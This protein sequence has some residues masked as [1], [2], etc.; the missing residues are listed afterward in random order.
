MG[1]GK[2]T[3]RQKMIGMMYLVLLALLAMNVSKSV[4]EAFVTLDTKMYNSLVL[5]DE[6]NDGIV[7]S[8]DYKIA[9]LE[10][11]GGSD[12]E[13]ENIRVWQ[14]RALRIRKLTNDISNYYVQEAADM[15]RVVEPY[16]GDPS[17]EWTTEDLGRTKFPDEP[18]R[19]WLKLH[20][21]SEIQV[22]DNYD[23]PT[24]MFIGESMFSPV[25]RGLEVQIRIHAYRDSLCV[26][27]A[28]YD[29]GKVQYSFSPPEVRPD[30]AGEFKE[31]EIALS[32]ALKT[33]NPEDTTRIKAV[34]KML[35]LPEHQMNHGQKYPWVAAQFDHS[36]IV[37]AAAIFTS[38]KVDCINAETIALEHMANKVQVQMFNFNKIT[39][40]AFS[41]SSYV[42]RGD[43]VPLS[44]MV[45]AYDSARPMKLRYW[46]NDEDRKAENMR[47]FEGM[48][49][50]K[51]KLPGSTPGKFVVNGELEVEVKGS[52]EWKAWS[53]AYTV[54]EPTGA[55]SLPEMNVLYRGYDNKVSGAASGYPSFEIVGKSNVSIR[56]SGTEHIASPGSGREAKIDIVG[57]AEDGSKASLGTFDFRVQNLPSPSIYF[58]A[59]EEGAEAAAGVIKAQ[60]RL[61]AKYP[62]EIPL[63][64]KFDLVSWEVNVTGAPKPESGN[65]ANLSPKALNLIKQAQKG[66][67]I[68]I[69]TNVKGPDGK[70]RKKGGIFKVK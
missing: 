36:P 21:L 30:L 12:E 61:F 50:H 65:G 19:K 22:K 2:E 51:L 57:V 6:K 1:G 18:D 28:T 7:N 69:M 68:S 47:E 39:P 44:V 20:P 32:E 9:S 66:T 59:L 58:G 17:G 35:T 29:G 13:K 24:H 46:I 62:P 53:F 45:A 70:I 15:I 34:Y 37:A 38:L 64:A 33:V 52:P 16:L 56:K 41:A 63:A 40:L 10:A 67:S 4:L 25:E 60:T 55:V 8:F 42:N 31:V 43:T 14:R 48:P 27:M 5:G 23:A 11:E 54:G 26:A 49:G 3:P